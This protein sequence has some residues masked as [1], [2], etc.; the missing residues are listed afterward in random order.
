MQ[1]ETINPIDSL[2]SLKGRIDSFFKSPARRKETRPQLSLDL[3][4]TSQQL[5]FPIHHNVTDFI[6]F[7]ADIVP[8]G[9]LYLFGGLLR[10]VSLFGRKAFN[11]DIDIVVEGDWTHCVEFL[12]R[13]GA[14]RNKFGGYRFQVGKWPIDIWK[15]EETWAIRRGLIRYDG[16]FSLTKTTVLNWDAILMN[17]KSKNLVCRNDYLESLV[18]RRLD[19]VL[20]ENP[21]P[22]GTAVRVFRHICLKDAR[23]LTSRA[24][25]YLASCTRKYSFA[26]LKE[27]EIA[28][29]KTS[30][31]DPDLFRWF[32]LIS[33]PSEGD[34]RSRAEVATEKLEVATEKLK[35]AGISLLPRQRELK[36][37]PSH[38]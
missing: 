36:L 16:I 17:W 25:D 3:D 9:N 12:E 22:K 23:Q 6:N 20:T 5:Q 32:E 26:E 33:Y 8:S 1:I 35:G 18:N 11:S 31:I 7:L 13:I 38:Y 34:T 29:Y 37:A 28:S 4:F 19:I 27:S 21:N 15:A 24:A 10:D 14:A 2:E 30:V